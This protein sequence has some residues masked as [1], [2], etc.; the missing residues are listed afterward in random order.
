MKNGLTLNSE[1]FWGGTDLGFIY[2]IREN[3]GDIA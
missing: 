3:R 1:V 2:V